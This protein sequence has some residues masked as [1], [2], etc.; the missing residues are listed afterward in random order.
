M[1]RRAFREPI[2]QKTT[3]RQG[4][5]AARG[6]RSLA[7]QVFEKPHHQHF[8]IHY[9]IDPLAPAFGLIGIGRPADLPHL[10]GEIHLSK[11]LLHPLIESARRRR[12]QFSG[13]NPKLLLLHPLRSLFEHALS[14]SSPSSETRF[15]NRLLVSRERSQFKKGSFQA[16]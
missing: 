13:R 14:Y 7:G 9:R 3:D 5:L 4:V 8:Q 12:R 6:D 1:I 15:F 10:P 11:R 16:F 2:A